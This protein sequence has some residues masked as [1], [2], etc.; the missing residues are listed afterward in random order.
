MNKDIKSKLLIIK[1][2]I[3]DYFSKKDDEDGSIWT[4]KGIINY[5][6]EKINK[7]IEE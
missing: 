7:L 4:E 3:E 5:V 6:Y 2:E 1:S